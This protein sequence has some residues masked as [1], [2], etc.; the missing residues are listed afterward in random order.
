M[1][2]RKHNVFLWGVTML[3]LVGLWSDMTS[4]RDTPPVPQE[5]QRY[6]AHYVDQ[7]SYVERILNAIGLTNQDI[8]RSFAL[9]AGISHYPNLSDPDL[10]PAAE[11]LRKLEDY[12][13][14]VEFFDEIVVLKDQD[15]L[16]GNLV[17]FFQ[18]YFPTRLKQY[19][20]SRFLFAYSGHGIT[21]GKRGYLLLH[22]AQ[23]T[24]D[25][26]NSIN[27]EVVRVLFHEVVDTG[28]H[29]LALI[30]ACY[31][32]TFL[33]LQFNP[34]QRF[35]PKYRGAHAITAGGTNELTWH[36][37][38][39]GTGSIFF[40]KFFEGLNG[41]ADGVPTGGDGI[42]TVNELAA[43]LK[44]TVQVSTDQHQNPRAGDILTGG[45]PG[46]LFFL[47]RHRQVEQGLMP[48]WPPEEGRAYGAS[49]P[50]IQKIAKLLE[51]A[52]AY[53]ARQWYTTPEDANAFDVYRE[54]LKLDPT[55]ARA[56][57]QIDEIAAFYKSR[58]EQEAQRSR[59]VQALEYYRKYLTIVPD[60][61]AV[62]DR[63]A[64]LE[65]P[66]PP[67]AA[68]TPTPTRR[69]STPTP[70]PPA[71]TPTP[72]LSQRISLRS[73]PI[74]VSED[75]FI[76]V[77]KLDGNWR[78]LEYIRNDFEDRGEVV[79]DRATGLMWQK[80]GS[81]TYM[82]YEKAQKYVQDLNRKK[83]AGYDDWRLP[84][85]PELISL[86][87]PEKQSND[88]YINPIFDATQRWCW[89]ADRRIK[90]EG[91]SGSAWNVDFNYG[92]VYGLNLLHDVYV[93][94]VRS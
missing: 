94:V 63:I 28:H 7:R 60:D 57:H 15:M 45:S 74:T 67:V 88:L 4:A 80:S 33:N 44:Q 66:S 30:N 77:F 6:F 86:L 51:Q 79:I 69:P 61:V 18:S 2:R 87:E 73:E 26:Q 90:G 13:K 72:I 59:I 34:G 93:R 62:L 78:P 38:T 53:F 56:H 71:S 84:T 42:V 36:D 21:E 46:G 22:T 91:S 31:G 75:K 32:G 58:A 76:Q 3:L 81:K 82:V 1:N 29:V 39:I 65:A 89:S 92:V 68:P 55:N 25:K 54:V 43:Y 8:G 70:R 9:I 41:Y 10:Q 52:D 50:Q 14:N 37:P 23:N 83:F 17:F 20:R 47:N 24:S 85:I 48:P 64:E 12:L 19:P 27:I 35:I 49:P 5:Y 11:D 16:Y 40:E